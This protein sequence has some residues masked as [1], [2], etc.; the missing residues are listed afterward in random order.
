MIEIALSVP[1]FHRPIQ[2]A[3][4]EIFANMFP[5]RPAARR[6]FDISRSDALIGVTL[7]RVYIAC[8]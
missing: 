4:I 3:H 7:F 8:R 6:S 1:P 2:I 5:P